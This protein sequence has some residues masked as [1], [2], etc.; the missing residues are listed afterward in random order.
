MYKVLGFILMK[1]KKEKKKKK[2][3]PSHKQKITFKNIVGDFLDYRGG[4]GNTLLHLVVSGTHHLQ[5]PV[6][7]YLT[8]P[9]SSGPSNLGLF[10]KLSSENL[11]KEPEVGKVPHKSL[12]DTS[13]ILR[14]PSLVS[15]LGIVPVNLFP[16]SRKNLRLGRLESEEGMDPV[17]LLW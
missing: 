8:N 2:K 10:L 9:I 4:I 12:S 15:C 17:K 5:L 16:F 14:L 6:I 7:S 13:R 3:K 11:E 1:H